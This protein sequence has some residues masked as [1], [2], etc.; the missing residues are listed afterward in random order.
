VRYRPPFELPVGTH[1]DTVKVHVCEDDQCAKEVRGS[2]ATFTASYTVSN[3]TSATLT[4]PSLSVSGSILE[5]VVPT[6]TATIQLTHAGTNPVTVM[7]GQAYPS[8]DSVT[9]V[10]GAASSVNLQV[11]FVRPAYLGVGVYTENVSV[12]V[13]YDQYC[14]REVQGSP[15][16]LQTT[17]TVNSSVPVE[18]GLTPVPY[19]TRTGLSHDV[20]DAEYSAALEAIVM[21]SSSPRNSLYLYDVASGSERELALSKP[22]TVVSVAPDGLSAAVGHD[23]LITH[24]NLATLGQ[25]GAPAPVV[26]NVSTNVFDIVLDGHGNVHALPAADQWVNVHS[27]N[28]ATNIETLGA[29]LLY[30]RTRGRLHPSG[31][32]MYTANN[33]LSPSD[34]AKFDLRSGTGNEM[35]DSPYHGDYAM[36]G[37][38]WMK[39]DGAT[40]YTK[41]G[42]TFRSS[43]TRSQD[44]I[45]SG[46]LQLSTAQFSQF[47]IRS[48]SQSDATKEIMLVEEDT[49]ECAEFNSSGVRCYTHLALYES[50]FLNRTAVYSIPPIDVG[51]TGYGQRGLLVFHSADGLHRYMI[52]RLHGVPGATQPFYLTVLQ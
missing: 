29:G 36:C 18:T 21:V 46:R 24:V 22:P 45:Y 17:Y 3:P 44:M 52:S 37:D 40:L 19:L 33:G 32:Y 11:N 51:G 13:C 42:N 7:L 26:L 15:L 30:A 31:D 47:V 20:I 14:S 25:P 2:P 38:V 27:V 43:E 4:T 16:T 6:G 39:Q 34:I 12:R 41:C 49:Y 8:I 50:D 28:I 1:S 10:S 48:L 35:Y 9:N 5:N 23:A